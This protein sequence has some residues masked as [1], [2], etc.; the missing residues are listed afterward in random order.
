MREQCSQF[1]ELLIASTL[2]EISETERK[3][4]EEHLADCPDCREYHRVLQ[5]D[6]RRLS[7][8]VKATE[9]VIYSLV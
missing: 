8:Y 6:D 1:E 9:P 3:I 2:H 7:A 4:L 5:E